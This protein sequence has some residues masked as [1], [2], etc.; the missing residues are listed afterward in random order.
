MSTNIAAYMPDWIIDLSIMYA[1]F[2]QAHTGWPIAKMCNLN[3]RLT[4]DLSSVYLSYL[5]K[6]KMA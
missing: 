2:M 5:N 6:S 1:N 4:S 3:D